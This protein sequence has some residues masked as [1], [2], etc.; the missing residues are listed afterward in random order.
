MKRLGVATQ[1]LQFMMSIGDAVADVRSAPSIAD[2]REIEVFEKANP[3]A[4]VGLSIVE[5]ALE[6]RLMRM[7]MCS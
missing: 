1:Y 3:A 4:K 5:V 6:V 7:C 2:I